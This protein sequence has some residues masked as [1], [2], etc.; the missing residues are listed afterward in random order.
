MASSSLPSKAMLASGAITVLSRGSSPMTASELTD[1]PLPDSPTSA[2]VAWAGTSNETPLSAS[3][4]ACLPTRNDTRRL[5][6]WSSMVI[7]D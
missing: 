5:R 1:L 7:P 6:T 3:K 2:T 4:V